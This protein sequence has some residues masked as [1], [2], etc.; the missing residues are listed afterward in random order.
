MRKRRPTI[1]QLARRTVCRTTLPEVAQAIF[2]ARRRLILD[3]C[4]QLQTDVDSRNDQY[5]NEPPHTVDM[6]FA[7]DLMAEEGDPNEE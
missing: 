3:E 7:K 1:E 6:D 2:Q 5:P 4:S